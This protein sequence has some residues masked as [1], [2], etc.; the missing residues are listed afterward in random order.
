MT[1]TDYTKIILNIK[2]D[3]IYFDENCLEFY[4]INNIE[5]KVFHGRLT[6]TPEY[7]GACGVVN[8]GFKDIIK[9]DWKKN[10]VIRMTKV[11]NYNTINKDSIVSIAII[12]LLLELM[13]LTFISKF[14]M[15][16]IL[17]LN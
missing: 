2:N 16:L 7:C 10:C 6:Y 13:L 5:T 4:K 8:E 15:I 3:N 11:S 1:H 12:L 9:W 14:P 17:L